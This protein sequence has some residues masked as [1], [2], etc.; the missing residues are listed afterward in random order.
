MN[1]YL[2]T[3]IFLFTIL[4]SSA[5]VLPIENQPQIWLKA[6]KVGL[7]PGVWSNYANSNYNAEFAGQT[8]FPDTIGINFH[9]AFDINNTPFNIINF[10]PSKKDRYTIFTVY[11]IADTISEY[12]LWQMQLDSNTDVKLSSTKT[13][14]TRS[15]I[16]YSQ[17]GNPTPI[18]NSSSQSW[19]RI[20]IDSTVCGL[21][22]AGTDSFGFNGKFAEFLVFKDRL[23]RVDNEKVHTYLALK[24][25]IGIYYLNYVNSEDTIIW[26]T[27]KDT[28]YQY[29]IIGLGRDDSLGI[30]Q[31]QT[32]AQG[33][34]SPM[35]MY[36]DTL[37]GYN[38]IN[39]AQFDNLNFAL[40]GHNDGSIKSYSEDTVNINSYLNLMDRR[41]KISLLGNSIHQKKF[42]IRMYAP[43][44]DT[45]LTLK[46]IINRFADDYFDPGICNIIEP[47][48]VDSFGYYYYENIYWDTDF[49]G[50]D[51]FTF[52]QM[53]PNTNNFRMTI[54]TNDDNDE[55]ED[56]AEDQ[57]LEH[58]LY[59]NPSNGE[60]TLEIQAEN[61]TAFTLTIFDSTGKR[62]KQQEY[63]GKLNY[64]ITET[65]NNSGN[66]LISLKA[67]YVN[68]SLK[69]IIK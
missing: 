14:N 60:F 12:G 45:S 58:K 42:N 36:V 24:Y 18:I 27:S 37:K 30:Y 5:Q 44:I 31:K 21:Q 49:S 34:T 25:G 11:Q 6:D 1:K 69:L 57:K 4:Y 33:G 56:N 63:S 35:L 55:S 7:S 17:N 38:N 66:Y 2:I 13:K 41:W 62:I 39:N 22:L 16:R 65:I 50:S 19:R 40:F 51:V 48:R 32:A 20:N 46:L 59:P 9:Q 8:L 68:E 23:Q 53:P 47:S 28:V 54:N 15:Y 3:T 43:D 67:K 52:S 26:N 10:F 61:K 29:D 64:K